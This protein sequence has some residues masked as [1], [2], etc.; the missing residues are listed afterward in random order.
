MTAPHRPGPAPAEELDGLLDDVRR[1]GRRLDAL[2]PLDDATLWAARCAL[3][4]SALLLQAY[5]D[6]NPETALEAV[7]ASRASVVAATDAVRTSRERP[8]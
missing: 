4:A 2:T 3:D 1:A 5:H 6:A 7:A 8:T